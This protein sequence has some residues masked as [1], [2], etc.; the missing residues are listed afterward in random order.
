VFSSGARN[1][2][3]SGRCHS[4]SK[5]EQMLVKRIDAAGTEMEKKV[6][7]DAND[8]PA[9]KGSDAQSGN[10]WTPDGSLLSPS[11]QVDMAALTHAGLV[12]TN[13]EDHYLTV[14]AERSLQILQTNLPGGLMPSRFDEFAYGLAVADGVGGSGAGDVASSTALTKIIYLV[15]HTSDWIMRVIE[16][17]DADRVMERMSERFRKIDDA[18]RALSENDP[19]LFGMGTTL[20][21]A[22]SRSR[23]LFIGHIGDSRAY[24]LRENKLHQLTQD[25][26]LAQALIDFGIAKPDDLATKAMRNV[27]TTC[28][29]SA[30]ER[31]EAEVQRVALE[32]GDQLLLCTDGLTEMV[33]DESIGAALVESDS[34]SRACEA[35]INLALSTGGL[36]NI[37]VA[38]ARYRFPKIAEDRP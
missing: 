25:H 21:V 9:N 6:M 32:D 28:I 24:L 27:L 15:I 38:L 7:N 37:T 20:T 19:A 29:G 22:I 26:T 8:G 3:R 10:L 4:R 23:D 11:A 12:R 17:Q 36:D 1:T 30:G 5:V 16:S 31:G 13:N 18:V 14:R 34:A 33:G 2:R 35:L